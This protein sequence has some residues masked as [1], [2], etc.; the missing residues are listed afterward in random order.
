[1]MSEIISILSAILSSSLVTTVALFWLLFK[2]PEKVEKWISMLAR[3][4]ARVSEKAAR[5][6]M[7]THIQSTI[8]GCRRGLNTR[9]TILPY[10]VS[11]KWTNAD[12]IQ[13]DLRDNRVVIMMKPYSSQGR[14]LA[15]V[16]SAYV[17]RALLPK[18]RRYVEPS[19]M[20]GIDHTV[21]KSILE[22]NTSA[23]EYYLSEI[24]EEISNEE[25]S[26]VVKMDRIHEQGTLTRLLLPELNRL[27]IL[28]P[29]EPDREASRETTALA[30]L[31]YEFVTRGPGVD[32]SPDFLGTHIRMAIV[33]VGESVKLLLGGT[34]SHFEFIERALHRGVDHFYVVSTGI[35]IK[36]AKDLVKDIQ[37]KLKLKEAYEEEYEGIFRGKWTRMFCALLG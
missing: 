33:P 10:G 31:M 27:S 6:H 34:L 24:M 7:A 15:H 18:A 30:H 2:H 23:L 4:V 19:L 29:R 21:C 37:Q 25:K 11:V 5:T 14:N 32:A 22:K 8:D 16:V 26:Y 36:Y 1:M 17:P 9:E 3:A 13:A 35:N 12:R 28:Y 20:S